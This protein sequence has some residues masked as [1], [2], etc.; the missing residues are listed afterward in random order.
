[1]LGHLVA[2]QDVRGLAWR[3]GNAGGH[4]TVSG[5]QIRPAHGRGVA[6]LQLPDEER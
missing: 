4:D 6:A 1:M 5:S 3:S 2:F